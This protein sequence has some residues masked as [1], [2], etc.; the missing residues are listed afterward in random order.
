MER[1]SFS[2]YTETFMRLLS[3]DGLRTVFVPPLLDLCLVF[4]A[5]HMYTAYLRLAVRQKFFV[6][7]SF[8][9][10]VPGV[11]PKCPSIFGPRMFMSI[12]NYI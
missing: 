3:D 11:F 8:A 10:F 2:R 6:F 12:R 7:W 9:D 5:C 1:L 4:E